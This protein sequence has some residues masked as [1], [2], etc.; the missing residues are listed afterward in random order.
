VPDLLG[1]FATVEPATHFV[2]HQDSA[3]E[4]RARLTGG[5]ADLVLTSPRPVDAVISWTPLQD[6][7]LMLA[8]PT[9]HRL[10][11]RS[12]L[13]LAE[14]IDEG[15]IAMQAEFGLRQTTDAMFA[16]RGTQPRIVLESAEI[17]TIKADDAYRTIGL[18]W[19]FD[20]PL[21]AA[22]RRFRSFVISTVPST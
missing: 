7:R 12:S 2:L 13:T 21:A 6:Q 16:R 20:R 22:A 9:A 11:G 10:A 3:D 5:R 4:V 19:R 14:V 17:A 1:R 8:V 15:F 18:A